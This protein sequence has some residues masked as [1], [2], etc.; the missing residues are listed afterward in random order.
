MNIFREKY[1]ELIEFR[2]NNPP[3]EGAYIEHHHIIPKSIAPELEKDPSNIVA[4][5]GK[6]H[7]KAHYFLALAMK[8]EGDKN[9]RKMLYAI[10]MMKMQIVKNSI[11]TDDELDAIAEIYEKAKKRFA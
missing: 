1:N 5:T 8:E 2:K 3:E 11:L 7:L 6:E 10:R 9:Y 4:L